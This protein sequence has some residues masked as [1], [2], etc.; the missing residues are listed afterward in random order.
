MRRRTGTALGAA[1]VVTPVLALAGPAQAATT[2]ALWQMDS[3]SVMTDSS[4]YGNDGKT[5]AIT[6]VAGSSGKGY[7]F[8]G[9]TS[10]V[11]VPDANS[12]DP[13]TAT[14][15]LTVHVRFTVPPSNHTGT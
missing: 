1:L 10:I 13:G 11:T 15:R 8:N 6:S 9:K 14:M 4:A 7:H 2:A 3:T 5:T 12:L